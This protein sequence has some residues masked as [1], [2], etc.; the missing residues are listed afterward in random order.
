MQRTE[1]NEL[2]VHPILHV[3]AK[4]N[5]KQGLVGLVILDSLR[6]RVRGDRSCV[7]PSMPSMKR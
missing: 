4:K 5:K 6:T 1:L 3:F 2:D 7:C